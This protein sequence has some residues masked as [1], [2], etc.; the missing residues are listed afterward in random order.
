MRDRQ[1][2]TLTSGGHFGAAEDHD[3]L[4]EAV[5]PCPLAPLPQSDPPAQEPIPLVML[6]AIVPLTTGG[7]GSGGC[8]CWQICMDVDSGAIPLDSRLVIATPPH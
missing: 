6:P 1:F 7:G 8:P 5:C 4:P 2:S 3:S